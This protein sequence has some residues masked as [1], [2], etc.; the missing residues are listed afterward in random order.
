MSQVSAIDCTQRSDALH[1][2]VQHFI[3]SAASSRE[4]FHEL[5]SCLVY[6]ESLMV[7]QGLRLIG[8]FWSV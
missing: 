7:K 1:G 8:R 4:P 6:I 3:R 2:R 5:E